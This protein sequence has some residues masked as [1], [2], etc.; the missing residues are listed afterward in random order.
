MSEAVTVSHS[1][2][3]HIGRYEVLLPL[4]TGGMATVFLARVPVAGDVYRQVALKLMHPQLQTED[5]IFAGMLVSEAK[6][7]ASIRHPNVVPVVEVG[8]D[9]RGV[10][11]VMDYVEGDT[12]SGIMRAARKTASPVP[13]PVV[14]RILSDALLGLHAAHELLSP[15]GAPLNLVHR[16]VS[17]QNLL[18]GS[19][20]I[21]RLTDFGIAKVAN[22][23]NPTAS[24]VIK[25]KVGYMSPEQALAQPLD[26][27]CDVWAAGVVAWELLALRR[28]H[29]EDHQVAILHSLVSETPPRLR[30]LRPDIPQ[31]VDDAIA[32]ALTIDVEKRCPSALELRKRLL[33]AWKE[34][35]P[36]ADAVDVGELV[37]GLAGPALDKRR[38]QVEAVLSAR[39]KVSTSHFSQ[40][41]LQEIDA[42]ESP[43][44]GELA[45]TVRSDHRVG[46]E[47]PPAAK[48]SRLDLIAAGVIAAGG[49]ALAA[50]FALRPRPP[51]APNLAPPLVA[52]S[53]ATQAPTPATSATAPQSAT[54]T[55]SAAPATRTVRVQ[56][57]GPMLALRIGQREVILPTPTQD[58]EVQLTE[59]ERGMPLGLTATAQDGRKAIAR[60]GIEDTTAVV[61]F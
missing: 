23:V 52:S 42:Q 55:P 60:I 10:F 29:E 53:S 56:A 46:A 22:Q 54:A 3:Q 7:A 37:R 59:E 49:I 57:N 40:Q 5:G 25:G 16:D 34:I 19:D 12:L 31:A 2:P 28:L 9:P 35:G 51:Q 24:G 47:G 14:A 20:G 1:V 27:R 44:T 50:S 17:P 11:L 45:A 61:S 48:R 8:E 39:E 18:V 32:S 36:V 33:D 15:A 41:A 30:S 13:L 58:V 26:R 38:M 43:S 21:S 4:G 6:V